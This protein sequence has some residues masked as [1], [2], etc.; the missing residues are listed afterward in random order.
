M[1]DVSLW[2]MLTDWQAHQ[3]HAAVVTRLGG[4]AREM[5]RVITPQEILHGWFRGGG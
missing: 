1:P 5:A 2:I 4:S 3:Q